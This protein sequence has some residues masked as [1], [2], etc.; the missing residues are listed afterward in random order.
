M[1]T[2]FV[3]S[4]LANDA[5]GNVIAYVTRS[6]V[7]HSAFITTDENGVKDYRYEAL[8]SKGYVRRLYV[9]RDKVKLREITVTDDQFERMKACAES[10][11]G[12]KYPN[13]LWLGLEY[14][15]PLVNHQLRTVYCSQAIEDILTIGGLYDKSR[16]LIKPSPGAMDAVALTLEKVT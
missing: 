3:E 14:V 16:A 4:H 1:R 9:P 12:T 8:R 5:A 15:I 10:M 13:V 2:L 11:V 7:Q 6:N